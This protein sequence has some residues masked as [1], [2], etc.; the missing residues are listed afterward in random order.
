M[1][2][3]WTKARKRI[4]ALWFAGAGVIF[5]TLLAQSLLGKYGERTSEAWS[6]FFPTVMPTLSLII[7]GVVMDAVGKGVR[8]ST[9]DRFFFGLSFFLSCCYLAGVSVVIFLEPFS[10]LSPFEAM[11][12]SNLWLGPFQ[13]LVSASLGAFF[14]QGQR[15]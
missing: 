7:G 8:I 9:V 3:S 12:Q 4:A 15:E 5:L 14:I 10:P 1:R 2:I 6:W 11:N 13:G